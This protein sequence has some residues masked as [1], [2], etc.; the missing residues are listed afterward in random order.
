MQI[1]SW[2]S[3]H[4]I[5]P[6]LNE[7]PSQHPPPGSWWVALKDYVLLLLRSTVLGKV[8][9]QA[10]VLTF[11]SSFCY[12]IVPLC[13][14]LNFLVC[15]KFLIWKMGVVIYNY[16]AVRGIK[17]MKTCKVPRT[18]QGTWWVLNN[19]SYYQHCLVDLFWDLTEEMAAMRSA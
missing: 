12:F 16:T 11:S 6:V 17:F 5:P 14:M 18:V 8:G 2:S 7:P 10:R 15:L 9:I 4:N 13:P 19:N 3:N 1:I